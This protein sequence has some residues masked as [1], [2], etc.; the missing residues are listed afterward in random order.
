[1]K[2]IFNFLYHPFIVGRVE[3]LDPQQKGFLRSSK[4]HQI[5][6]E[7]GDAFEKEVSEVLHQVEDATLLDNVYYETGNFI[8]EIGVYESVQI[9]HILITPECV[10]VIEDKYLSD[11]K[12]LVLEFKGSNKTWTLK[13][14]S[15]KK[16]RSMSGVFQNERH[17]QCLVEILE[18]HG[19][20]D[21][22]IVPVTV[23]GGLSYDKI[24]SKELG[25]AFCVT[26]EN[27][28]GLICIVREYYGNSGKYIEVQKAVEFFRCTDK[29]IERS[30]LYYCRHFKSKKMPKRCEGKR[31]KHNGK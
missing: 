12:Y 23:I 22:P 11:D 28:F 9:D 7:E 24:H 6:K 15:G 10:F 25:D 26:K 2:S 4:K 8:P 20:K 16:R 31:R 5:R 19:I 13:L 30:H 29:D 1:M 17:R 14:Y 27:L 21:I 18:Y 3:D